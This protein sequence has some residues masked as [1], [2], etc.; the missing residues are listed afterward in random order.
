M[1]TLR[2]ARLTISRSAMFPRARETNKGGA[3]T[4]FITTNIGMNTDAIR[5]RPGG[6]PSSFRSCMYRPIKRASAIDAPIAIQVNSLYPCGQGGIWLTACEEILHVYP[7][8]ISQEVC[9]WLPGI[10]C[11]T[12]VDDMLLFAGDQVCNPQAIGE[13]I[14]AVD[15][16][17]DLA[18]VG[19]KGPVR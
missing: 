18:M 16:C 19:Q 8:P 9:V 4:I 7:S 12:T 6:R 11:R 17:T 3:T 14:A 10:T 1:G 15:G 2:S 5:D 13:I